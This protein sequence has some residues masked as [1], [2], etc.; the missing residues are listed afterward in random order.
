AKTHVPHL[1]SDLNQ[2]YY[3][4]EEDF[5]YPLNDEVLSLWNKLLAQLKEQG[6]TLKKWQPPAGFNFEELSTR[7]SKIIAYESYL[8]H[9][10]DAENEQTK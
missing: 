4:A 3:L 1:R 7:T 6:F 8:Y 2:L 9:G 5:P 10:K